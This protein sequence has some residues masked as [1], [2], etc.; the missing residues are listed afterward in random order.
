MMCNRLSNRTR[1]DESLQQALGYDAGYR[2]LGLY[3][4]IRRLVIDVLGS[5]SLL[6]SPAPFRALFWM[7]PSIS[8]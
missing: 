1:F 4:R 8:M 3:S 6:G 2:G 7:G 5:E